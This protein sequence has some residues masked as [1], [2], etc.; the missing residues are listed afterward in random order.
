MQTEQRPQPGADCASCGRDKY[1][2]VLKEEEVRQLRIEST[3]Q[4]ILDRLEMEDR[5]PRVKT[6][7]ISQMLLPSLTSSESTESISSP[8]AHQIILFPVKIFRERNTNNSSNQHRSERLKFHITEEM[9]EAV[10]KS[11]VLW[12]AKLNQTSSEGNNDINILKVIMA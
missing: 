1:L 5:P 3:K 10:L 2:A 12:T 9:Y 8:L 4:Q 11:A 6:K 7:D